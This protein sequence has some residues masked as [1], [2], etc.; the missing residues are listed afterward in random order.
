MFLKKIIKWLTLLTVLLSIC[1]IFAGYLFYK[2]LEKDLPDVKQLQNVQYQVPL[3]IYSADN[4]LIARFGEKKRF[5]IVIEDVPQQLINAFLAAE[6]DRFF[7]HPGVDYKGLLRAVTQLILTGKKKQ[8]GS[9]ITMQVTRN[10]LLSR[11]KTYIRKIKEIILALKIEQEYSKDKILQ[12]YL[13]KIYLGHRSYGIVAA[14][15]TYYGKPLAELNLAQHAMIAGLPKAP[16]SYNPITNPERALLRRNYV[17]KRMLELNSIDQAEFDSAFHAPVTASLEREDAE[18]KASHIAEMVR[19]QIYE[20][21]GEEAYTQGLNVITTISSTL[22]TA[23]NHA[24]QGTLHAYDQRHGYRGLPHTNQTQPLETANKIGDTELA[25]VAMIKPQSIDAE[26]ADLSIIHIDWANI[27]WARRFKSRSHLG[28]EL[29]STSDL[30]SLNDV[31]RVRQLADKSWALAQ[32]PQIEGAFIALNPHNGAIMALSGGFD[33]FHNKFNRITQSKRQPGS[34]F[35]PIIYTTALEHGY[36]PAS[37][38]N[39]A[40]IVLEDSIDSNWRPENYSR[41]FYGPTS[42]RTALRKSRNLIS[43]RLLRDIG[44]EPVKET[45]S[46]FGFDPDQL[47]DS[48]SLALGSGQATPLQMA[49]MY[50]T[51]ANGGF[52]I[53]PF[54]IQSIKNNKGETLYSHLPK[55]ACPNCEQTSGNDNTYA[56]RIIKPEI[57]FLM[58]S[59]LQ[60]VVR[61]GTATK[62][63]ILN[64]ADLAGKTGTTNDQRDTWFNGFTSHLV[65]TAWVGFDD[66]TPMGR[67]ETGGKTALPMWIDFMKTALHNKKELL[68]EQ[69]KNIQKAYIDPTTGLLANSGSN[70]I[71]EF[72]QADQVPRQY[73]PVEPTFDQGP[74]SPAELF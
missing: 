72:F 29:K 55:I 38:I 71:W 24:L 48:L 23:S 21:F 62:A 34:G 33:F 47:P 63:K 41:K 20:Q 28:E 16:S 5:P 22:Q 64:R 58:N 17:L 46:R 49:R 4:L 44:I 51:F 39:D 69:P 42:L 68:P 12:L 11:E 31:I 60:D 30:F 57:N 9:T 18:L 7:S 50:A 8:G 1:L 35:K 10:F 59:L 6:D 53:D 45:A 43:I 37:I 25:R 73:S 67:G 56:P 14:A 36:T 66:S 70:G 40:P 27:N 74:Q 3:S 19:Q 26:L 32:V 2:E 15:Q 61:R 13:N 65:A 54:F 52:L